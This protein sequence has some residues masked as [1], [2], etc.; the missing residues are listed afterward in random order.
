[1]SGSPV[2]LKILASVAGNPFDERMYH[3]RFKKARQRGEWFYRSADI[4]AEIDRLNGRS[5]A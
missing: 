1:M 2:R 3:G 5:D 4:V